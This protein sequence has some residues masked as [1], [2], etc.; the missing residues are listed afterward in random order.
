MSGMSW[1][2]HARQTR[3]GNGF[4]TG[5]AG[6]P[7]ADETALENFRAMTDTIRETNYGC[8]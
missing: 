6:Y 2:E 5:T 3:F 7:L 8:L 1:E 4:Y